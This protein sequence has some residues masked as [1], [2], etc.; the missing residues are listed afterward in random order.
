MADSDSQMRRSLF[1]CLLTSF[2]PK[3]HI[4]PHFPYVPL[5]P[6]SVTSPSS[7][8]TLSLRTQ[9]TFSRL[10]RGVDKVIGHG[11]HSQTFTDDTSQSSELVLLFSIPISYRAPTGL[12]LFPLSPTC[13]P[14]SV[15]H[16]QYWPITPVPIHFP[17]SLH[18]IYKA[19]RALRL[20]QSSYSPNYFLSTFPCSFRSLS[21]ELHFPYTTLSSVNSPR[22]PLTSHE[23]KWA[24]DV[25]L[26]LEEIPS[27][28]STAWSSLTPASREMVGMRPT[29]RDGSRS[30]KVGS[31]GS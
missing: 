20:N 9:L 2:Y 4:I 16:F 14:L 27:T 25:V 31:A 17:L 6:P 28:F 15:Y 1:V 10:N 18:D 19:V 13:P 21:T 12:L 24:L 7:R 3:S 5:R 26:E 22:C 8:S 23:Q 29:S 11:G 30:E